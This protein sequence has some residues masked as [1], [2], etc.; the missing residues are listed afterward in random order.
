MARPVGS[1]NKNTTAI[2]DMLRSA[3]E[4]KGGVEYFMKQ[5]DENPQAFMSLLGKTIPADVNNHVLL[6][7]FDSYAKEI[8]DEP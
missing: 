1:T 3:L 8:R 5:A 7:F 4:R 2:K 6:S